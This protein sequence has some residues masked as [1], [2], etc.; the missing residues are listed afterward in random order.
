[1]I[2]ASI[3]LLTLSKNRHG[4]RKRQVEALLLELSTALTSVTEYK[5]RIADKDRDLEKIRTELEHVRSSSS[6]SIIE[7]DRTRAEL[8]TAYS[9]LRAAEEERDSFRTDSDKH[10]GTSACVRAG[11]QISAN[12]IFLNRRAPYSAPRTYR[13]QESSQRNP[14]QI[15]VHT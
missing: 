14:Y 1:M 7:H 10:H 2:T 13:P 4:E 15:R 5:K 9:R 11:C 6:T 8:E 3:T 12:M